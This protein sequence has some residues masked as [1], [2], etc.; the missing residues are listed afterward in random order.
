VP[1]IHKPLAYKLS[2]ASS[3][4]TAALGLGDLLPPS[5]STQSPHIRG[6][7]N[8]PIHGHGPLGEGPDSAAS[9]FSVSHMD[10]S[11]V[12]STMVPSSSQSSATSAFLTSM[13]ASGSAASSVSLAGG[14]PIRPLDYSV[15]LNADDVHSELVR[16]V[17]DLAVWLSVVENGLTGLLEGVSADMANGRGVGEGEFIEEEEEGGFD[18]EADY[19]MAGGDTSGGE[20]GW[21]SDPLG[22]R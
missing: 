5:P 20:M 3:N 8:G 22:L 13:S 2:P 15:L 4:L 14:P 1:P 19:P 17:D 18:S 10:Y 6:F 7:M 16:S 9:S 21:R 11:M 12:S